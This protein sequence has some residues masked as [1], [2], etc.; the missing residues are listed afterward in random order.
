MINRRHIRVKVMQSVYALTHAKSDNIVKEEKFLRQSIDKLYDLY[1]LSLDMIVRVNQ[2]AEVT[3]AAAKKKHLVTSEELNPNS[4]F[5]DNKLIN[6]LKHSISLQTYIEENELNNWYLNDKFVGN[7]Y[8]ELLESDL[9]KEYMAEEETSYKKDQKFTIK[10]FAQFIAPNE[11][12][13]EY[14]EGE[15]ISWADDI[16]FVNTWVVKTLQELKAKN[17]FVIGRLYKNSD[18]EAFASELFKKTVLNLPNF[19]EEIVDKTPNWETDR[20]A[21]LDMIL[22]KMGI[23]EFLRFP[24][25]PVKVTIN[26]YLEIAKD[27]STDKSSVFINGVLDKIWKD[28]DATDRLNKIG[29]GML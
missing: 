22:I 17:D 19:E 26:E 13:S 4:K 9:Y 3:Q 21:D 25:I 23:C 14:F 27:Y 5:I 28:F 7:I 6:K 12:L 11:K 8:T 29:R 15:N 10:F 24:S 1:I 2:L 20:I 16:P 18:D